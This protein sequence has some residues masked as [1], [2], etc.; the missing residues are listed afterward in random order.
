MPA[1]PDA[2]VELTASARRET[3][4]AVPLPMTAHAPTVDPTATVLATAVLP[5]SAK[6]T[7]F[8]YP[9]LIHL[10]LSKNRSLSTSIP[11]TVRIFM[12]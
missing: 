4:L 7:D 9:Y 6:A 8:E 11:T 12:V 5:A 2:P 10:S 1:T 3:A